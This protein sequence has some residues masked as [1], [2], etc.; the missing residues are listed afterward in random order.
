[1]SG[2]GAAPGP[3]LPPPPSAVGDAPARLRG[4]AFL[5]GFVVVMAVVLLGAAAVSVLSAPPEP[6]ADCQPGLDCGG[7]PPTESDPPG[8][9]DASPAPSGGGGPTATPAGSPGTPTAQPSAGASPGLSGGT[10]G[11]RA[12]TPWLSSELGFEFEYYASLW[13]VVQSDARGVSLRAGYPARLTIEGV[14]AGEAGAQALLDARLAELKAEVPDLAPDP[15][16]RNTILGPAIGFVDGVG[17]SFAGSVTNAQGGTTPVGVTVLAASDGRI[18]VVLTLI[19]DNPE[20]N[21]GRSWRQQAARG[22]VSIV[23]KTFRW[24]VPR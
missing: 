14:P 11:I 16:E 15:R 2:V 1:M 24:S 3:T 7:P 8:R 10:V 21:R 12:G 19:V 23:V 5:V 18:S 6:P 17:G 9:P 4:P 13:T 22:T 20:T